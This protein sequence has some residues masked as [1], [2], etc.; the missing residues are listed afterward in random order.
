MPGAAPYPGGLAEAAFAAGSLAPG[1][2]AYS[3]ATGIQ[4]SVTNL[5]G[6][7]VTP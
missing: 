7:L 1:L 2:A 3:G 5:S 6:S 4:I